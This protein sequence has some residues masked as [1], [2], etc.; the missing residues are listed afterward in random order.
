MIPKQFYYMRGL[1][2]SE[3]RITIRS[4]VKRALPTLWCRGGEYRLIPKE[5]VQNAIDSFSTYN[6]MTNKMSTRPVVCI[7]WDQG[8][9]VTNQVGRF[10]IGEDEF[11]DA[12]P[13][14]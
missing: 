2:D 7:Y 11:K 10:L 8:I 6:K 13:K 5:V 1:H 3:N 9:P 12:E 4:N 14:I